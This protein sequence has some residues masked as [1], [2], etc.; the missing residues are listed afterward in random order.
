MKYHRVSESTA[1]KGMATCH[2]RQDWPAQRWLIQ[3]SKYTLAYLT[4]EMW[5]QKN[6][7]KIE[8]L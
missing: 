7:L 1:M 2:E 8:I 6:W 4:L 5:E 3:D